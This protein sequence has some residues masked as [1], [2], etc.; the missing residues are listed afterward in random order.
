MC[1]FYVLTSMWLVG[2]TGLMVWNNVVLSGSNLSGV[3]GHKCMHFG[4]Y[5]DRMGSIEISSSAICNSVVSTM[6]QSR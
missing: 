6:S 5:Q 3:K 2:A 1:A 4:V